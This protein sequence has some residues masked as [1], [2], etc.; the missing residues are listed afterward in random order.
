MIRCRVLGPVDADV[1]G[2]PAPP[3]LL[4]RKHLA[5]LLYL[6]R[7]PRLTRSR[8]HLIGLLWPEKDEG[9]ARHSLNEALRILRRS[10]G[11]TALE[12]S[13]TADR[14]LPGAVRL[15]IEDLEEAIGGARWEAASRLVAGEFLEGFALPGCAGFEDWLAAERRAWSERSVTALVGWSAQLLGTGDAPG[16]TGA[17]DRAVQLDPYSDAAIR[18]VMAA[19]AVRGE[20]ARALSRFEE[21]VARIKRDLD[22]VPA[23]ETRALA[24][25][26]GAARG[27]RILARAPAS[28][29][30]RRR[31]PLVGRKTELARVLRSL[32]DH[33]NK[34]QALLLDGD[35]G[36][37]K[38][39]LLDE[40]R[41][42][43]VLEGHA[44]ALVRAVE[45]DR[46]SEASGLIGLAR[47][48]LLGAP[49]VAATA[50]AALATIG[51]KVPEWADRFRTTVAPLAGVAEAFTAVIDAA[52]DAG[53][54]ALLVDD[55]QW[56]DRTSTLTLAALL[57]NHAT[58]PLTI[59]FASLPH[60]PRE[61]LDRL[62]HG[63]GRDHAGVSLSLGPL[64]REELRELAAWAFPQYD[65]VALERLS[66]RVASDSAGLPFLA[67]ELL[68][69]VAAGLEFRENDA[70]WPAP[71]RTLRLCPATFPTPSAPRCGSATA[72]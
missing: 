30:D 38:S 39:R 44:V 26:I 65:G 55:A 41:T 28:E 24:D 72:D 10:A 36:T 20:T 49:G 43:L 40:I 14:L 19:L 11:D 68:A 53:P 33:R 59:A 1:D 32:N 54:V 60:P 42:R 13:A 9:A 25:R 71:L 48:G 27:P 18:G 37:G 2:R 58:A 50:P 70:A 8:D 61:E 16:A 67:V 6:A 17:A 7:S 12:T 5:L 63:L 66:R 57:R 21:F 15:D 51:E 4:W 45:A 47:G 69:G 23:R 64:D 3:E 46:E 52:V 31:P 34:S 29:P 62:R 22:G 35:S 56:L